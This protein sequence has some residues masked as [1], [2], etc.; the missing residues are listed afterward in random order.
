MKDRY[1]M[2]GLDW[3]HKGEDYAMDAF[4]YSMYVFPRGKVMPWWQRWLL[5]LVGTTLIMRGEDTG[6]ELELIEWRGTYYL[7]SER[8]GKDKKL[9]YRRHGK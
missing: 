8:Y 7:V 4:R 5:R 2:R 3:G 1:T 6:Y 9:V